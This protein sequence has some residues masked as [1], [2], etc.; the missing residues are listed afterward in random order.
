MPGITFEV[1]GIRVCFKSNTFLIR[2]VLE[3]H[4]KE[5][6]TK[7]KP[8]IQINV[9]YSKEQFDKPNFDRFIFKD[10]NSSFG[11]KKKDIIFYNRRNKLASLAI[12]NPRNDNINF[13]TQEKSGHL[14]LYLF[15]GILYSMILYK[16]NAI[17]LHA[18]AVYDGRRAYV[19]IA[20]SGGDKSTISRLA[21]E[22]GY[23]VLNDDRVIVKKEKGKFY[24]YGNPWHGEIFKTENSRLRLD[25]IYF[26]RKSD[27]NKL[28]PCSKRRALC[29][30]MKNMFCLADRDDMINLCVELVEKSGFYIFE[31]K[32]D[33]SLW[34]F[35]DE[36]NE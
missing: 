15:P 9:K 13:Y 24:I 11:Y 4:Y 25:G 18:S 28:R 33:N 2:R 10:E 34:G 29:G 8:N 14:L 26:I 31:F 22:Q 1:A 35:L 3:N 36:H 12:F 19:F 16:Y 5:Y 27:I 30:I 32:K 6:L 20:P 17:M 21:L 7:K 23:K